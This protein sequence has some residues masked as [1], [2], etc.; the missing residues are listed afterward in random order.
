MGPVYQLCKDACD[1]HTAQQMTPVLQEV[2]RSVRKKAVQTQW[3][4]QE[5]VAL[6]VEG[7][8]LA[9]VQPV[10]EKDGTTQ[11]IRAWR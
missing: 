8:V 3:E 7:P 6:H 11:Y 4:P 5:H 1:Q 9:T 10:V 2:F